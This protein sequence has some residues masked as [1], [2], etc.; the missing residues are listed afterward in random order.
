MPEKKYLAGN[1]QNRDRR[2]KGRNRS[3][4][5]WEREK[6]LADLFGHDRARLELETM[7]RPHSHISESLG[8]I[9]KGFKLDEQSSISQLLEQWNDL[10]GV[11][12]AS[13]SRP[14]SVKGRCLSIEVD[15][16]AALYTLENFLKD[17]VLAK[18]KAV[19][20]KDISSI[21]FV[22]AGRRIREE[23]NKNKL[24]K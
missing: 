3:R 14:I 12:V 10:V 24:R 4:N 19:C 17:E 23:A 21:R 8:K 9:F 6:T 18:V 16:S 22:P 7:Q 1:E 11:S 20:P 15:N 13:Y 5:E 2:N